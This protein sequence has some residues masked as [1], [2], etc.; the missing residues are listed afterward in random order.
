MKPGIRHFKTGIDTP[1][2]DS[3]TFSVC[4]AKW[5]ESPQNTSNLCFINCTVREVA[6]KFI[7]DLKNLHKPG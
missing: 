4:L 2:Y 6:I 5:I 1:L 3:L 7:A